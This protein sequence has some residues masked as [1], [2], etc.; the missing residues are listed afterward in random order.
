MQLADVK[1]ALHDN[2]KAAQ[3]IIDNFDHVQLVGFGTFSVVF[4]ANS[5]RFHPTKQTFALKVVLALEGLSD[6]DI[7]KIYN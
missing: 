4:K 6:D 1:E 5:T 2:S 7:K 3:F